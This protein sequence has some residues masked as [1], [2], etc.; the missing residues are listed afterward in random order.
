MEI[1]LTEEQKDKMVSKL[2][3]ATKEYIKFTEDLRKKGFEYIKQ[4]G[5]FS[6]SSSV[7]FLPKHLEGKVFRVL[8]LPA[9]D[10]YEEYT[11]SRNEKVRKIKEKK[12]EIKKM[13]EDQNDQNDQNNPSQIEIGEKGEVNVI[14][15]EVENR[16]NLLDIF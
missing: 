16:K 13:E 1:E 14:P 3:V 4:V 12:E 9:P 11:K 6:D 8:L 5:K 7:I 10:Y 15:E 2:I